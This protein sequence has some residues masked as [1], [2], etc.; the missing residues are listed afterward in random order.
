[1]MSCCLGVQ[2]GTNQHVLCQLAE[3]ANRVNLKFTLSR[4]C[5]AHVLRQK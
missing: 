3:I 2:A 4:N 1:M 5:L